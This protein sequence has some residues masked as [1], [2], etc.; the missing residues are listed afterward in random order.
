MFSINTFPEH[1][2]SLLKNLV[3]LFFLVLLGAKFSICVDLTK[4]DSLIPIRNYKDIMELSI[5]KYIFLRI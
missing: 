2:S 1:I 4:I 5:K 3:C